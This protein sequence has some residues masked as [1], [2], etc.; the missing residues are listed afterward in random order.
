MG[1]STS[2]IPERNV[3]G[4]LDKYYV[5]ME[6]KGPA[7]RSVDIRMNI[8]E[9]RERAH[10]SLVAALYELEI[11][12]HMIEKD[13]MIATLHEVAN[14][15]PGYKPPYKLNCRRL[16]EDMGSNESVFCQMGGRI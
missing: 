6:D 8:N 1:G 9:K 10:R 14:C 2:D 16:K 11:P 5:N 3:Q 7:R 15:G 12:F 13:V 4:T